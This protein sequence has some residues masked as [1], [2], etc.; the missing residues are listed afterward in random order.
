M[1]DIAKLFVNA[2]KDVGW[3]NVVQII[4]DNVGNIKFVDSIVEQTFPHIIW[5]PH[6][7]HCLNLSFKSMCQPY[8]K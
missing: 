6:V 2:I 4:I 1:V 5:T 3:N 8:E 7:A